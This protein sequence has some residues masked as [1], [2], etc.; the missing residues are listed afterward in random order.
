MSNRT[1]DSPFE[2][3]PASVTY[4]ML[5]TVNCGTGKTPRLGVGKTQMNIQQQSLTP[6]RKS[7]YPLADEQ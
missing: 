7:T 3:A 6:Y 5:K 2:R 1:V 4:T